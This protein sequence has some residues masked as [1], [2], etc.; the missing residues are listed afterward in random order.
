MTGDLGFKNKAGYDF[1]LTSSSPL[2]GK[3]TSTDLG[4][5]TDILGNPVGNDIGAFQYKE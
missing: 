4:Y 1:S 2:R 5:T 3:A